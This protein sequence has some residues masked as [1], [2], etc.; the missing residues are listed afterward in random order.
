MTLAPVITRIAT[1]F[2]VWTELALCL[3]LPFFFAGVVISLALTRSPYP[4]PRV[5]GVD[6]V[7]AASGAIGALLLLQLTDGPRRFSGSRFSPRRARLPFPRPGIGAA[8]EAKPL[9][10]TWLLERQWIFLVLLARCDRS[11]RISSTASSRS[12]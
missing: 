1:T 7:G 8:P 9:F 12:R 10:H 4:V 5:Y 6:L 3:S 11:I 2:W